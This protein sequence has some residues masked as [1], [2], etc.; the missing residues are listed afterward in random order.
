MPRHRYRAA[1]TDGRLQRGELDALNLAELEAR[2]ARIGMVLINGEPIRARRLPGRRIPRRDLVSFCFHLEH[3]VAAGVPILEGL[4]DL[5]ASIAEP[6]LREIIGTVAASVE[7]GQTLSAACAAHPEAFDA[8]F[9]C[10]LRA[11]EQA[12]RL[13]QVLRD[14]AASLEQADELAAYTRRIAIYPAFVAT[15][16]LAAVGVALVFVIP[17]VARLFQSIGQTLPLQTRMLVALSAFVGEHGALLVL[18][19]LGATIAL[20]TAIAHVPAARARYDAALLR[21][22]V[23]GPLL[24]KLLLARVCKLLGLM[25][26]AGI[27]IVDALR[28]AADTAGNTA[29]RHG[30]R[31]AG[32]RIDSGHDLSS[33]IATAALFPPLLV[34]MLH[35]GEQSGALDVALGHL[36]RYYEREVRESIQR[37]QAA[38]EPL[39]TVTLG[40]LLLWIMSAVLGPVYD[41]LGRLPF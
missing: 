28:T 39:L 27:P 38:I 1:G 4:A 10:L 30:L 33:A 19:T 26:E 12:G 2:L 9:I 23:C 15:I 32:E 6:R 14:L 37:L 17:E 34:R 36:V 18:A 5:R 31:Q 8:L 25:Y 41:I 3:L 40:G 21:L 29:V 20:R 35:V 16:L 11:G 13:P 7:G 22:P 24:S